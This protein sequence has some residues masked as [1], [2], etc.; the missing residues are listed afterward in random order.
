MLILNKNDGMTLMSVMVSAALMGVVA[1]AF[2]RLF[3]NQDIVIRTVALRDERIRIL[4]HYRNVTIGG[5]DKTR[6]VW[7]GSG[8]IDVYDRSGTLRIAGSGIKLGKNGLYQP[9]PNG[10]WS[11]MADASLGSGVAVPQSYS[12]SKS[13]D[14]CHG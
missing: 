3:A 14:H 10:W 1:L 4:E 11:V 12:A 7:A 2:I 6:S 8:A 5:W 13:E 9:D